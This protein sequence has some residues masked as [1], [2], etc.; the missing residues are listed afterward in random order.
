VIAFTAERCVRSRAV[1]ASCRAC[2]D[3]C[4]TRAVA[5]DGLDVV[6]DGSRC[7]DCGAC[8]AACPTQ[9][10]PEP[11]LE[12]RVVVRCGDGVACVGA[13]SVEALLG[14]GALRV[15]VGAAECRTRGLHGRVEGRLAEVRSLAGREILFDDEPATAAPG[16]VVPG[17][18]GARLDRAALDPAG[19]R[20]LEVPARRAAALAAVSGA[21]AEAAAPFASAKV[22][23][24]GT[25]T[26]CLRCV[27]VCPTG[28]LRTTALRDALRF[29][30][31]ACVACGT[32]HDVCEPGALTRRPA[33]AGDLAGTVVLGRLR[34]RPCGECGA[35]FHAVGDEGVCPQCRALDDEAVDLLGW[36]R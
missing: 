16:P 4:P 28:A 29:D 6:V 2:V 18:G 36:R 7:V 33:T 13:V 21:P 15:L 8:G 11:P 9:A 24:V 25:C 20:R 1:A 30:A 27:A 19:L 22:L 17:E 14:A 5:L 26:G 23:D 34:M 32:C 31:A 35:W 10:F 12:A 3:A